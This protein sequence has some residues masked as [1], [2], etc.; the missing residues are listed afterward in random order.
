MAFGLYVPMTP[1]EQA[2]ADAQAQAD[3][4]ALGAVQTT[5]P[6][7]APPPMAAAPPPEQVAAPPPADPGTTGTAAT[8]VAAAAPAV[9]PDVTN[10]APYD[11]ALAGDEGTAPVAPPPE[12]APAPM[13]GAVETQQVPQEQYAP[14]PPPANGATQYYDPA[15]DPQA[16]Y[17][18]QPPP[19]VGPTYDDQAAAARQYGTFRPGNSP[20]P[21]EGTIAGNPDVG[22][23]LDTIAGH[24]GVGW[25]PQTQR[26]GDPGTGWQPYRGERGYESIGGY[27]PEAERV[28]YTEQ[29][30]NAPAMG[31]APY[32]PASPLMSNVGTTSLGG[33]LAG[34]DFPTA[35]DTFSKGVIGNL[36]EG[37]IRDYFQLDPSEIPPGTQII[38]DMGIIP[39]VPGAEAGAGGG[40]FRLEV[41]GPDNVVTTSEHATVAEAA[42]AG[43]QAPAGSFTRIVPPTEVQQ[44]ALQGRD[45]PV[46]PRTIE[47]PQVSAPPPPTVRGGQIVSPSTSGIPSEFAESMTP[48]RTRQDVLNPADDFRA[49]QERALAQAQSL[50]APRVQPSAVAAEPVV[51][52]PATGGPTSQTLPA[53]YRLEVSEP[54]GGYRVS[55][56]DDLADASS[57]RAYHESQGRQTMLQEVGGGERIPR[58]VALEPLTVQGGQRIPRQVTLQPEVEAQYQSARDASL[59]E[60]SANWGN[61]AAARPRGIPSE[62]IPAPPGGVPEGTIG[63]IEAQYRS[64]GGA[65][66]ATLRSLTTPPEG[67]FTAQ[68]SNGDTFIGRR[69]E[70][71]IIQRPAPPTAPPPYGQRAP[72]NEPVP[73]PP[74]E[75]TTNVNAAPPV[76][77]TASAPATTG[78]FRLPK[79]VVGTVGALGVAGGLVA[80][81]QQPQAPGARPGEAAP[82]GSSP[83]TVNPPNMTD[84]AADALGQ[85]TT[86]DWEKVKKDDPDTFL[87]TVVP[88]PIEVNGVLQKALM[89]KDVP[90]LF[91]GYIDTNGNAVPVGSDV[92]ADEYVQMLVANAGE[93]TADWGK[94]TTQPTT[95]GGRTLA[96]QP[97]GVSETPKKGTAGNTAAPDSNAPYV[98]G[99][100]DIRSQAAGTATSPPA[101][102]SVSPRVKEVVDAILPAVVDAVEAAPTTKSTGGK[103]SGGGTYTPRG[104]GGSTYTPRSSGSGGGSAYTRKKKRT[105][106]GTPSGSSMFGEG[107]PFNRPNSEIRD[108]ILAAIQESQAAGKARKKR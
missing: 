17:I 3:A 5:D 21:P 14:A 9:D 71:P 98:P 106:K 56:H 73:P 64:R 103:S 7:A 27:N 46:Q 10:Q 80:T 45:I 37:P 32:A 77:P 75:T 23:Q 62:P 6:N 87:N 1:E 81:R 70:Q 28:R 25:Q 66:D 76:T 57:Q 101:S 40:R 60:R 100:G 67:G 61:A 52:P 4:Q 89:S 92:S 69:G 107:F 38:N 36:P 102:P 90:G 99:A 105:K 104:S 88:Q 83:S 54:E 48:G 79:K 97:A 33:P 39:F 85:M 24:P 91:L 30:R 58:P 20:Q 15:M 35:L 51:R 86:A 42:K 11:P 26:L 96:D 59:A 74:T 94:S 29:M 72:S 19:Y 44:A 108:Y 16:S 31:A 84:Q 34:M 63:Q 47:D 8:D 43:M 49:S 95:S 53:R 2:A 78:R 50:D 12:A 18:A 22:W 68:M 13:L 93:A 82:S 65:P 55:Y 41:T